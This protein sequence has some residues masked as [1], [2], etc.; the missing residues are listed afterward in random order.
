MSEPKQLK[1]GLAVRQFQCN[2]CMDG[3]GF[4]IMIYSGFL[5][6]PGHPLDGKLIVKQITMY[7]DPLR[8]NEVAYKILDGSE[9]PPEWNSVALMIDHY[10]L[11]KVT[12]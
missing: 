9:N 1:T 10:K 2:S 7:A 12:R 3:E 5:D 8:K 11:E 4:G 6:Y